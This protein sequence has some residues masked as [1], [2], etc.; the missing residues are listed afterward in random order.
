MYG[1][2]PNLLHPRS[3]EMFQ[4]ISSD[5]MSFKNESLPLIQP[6]DAIR[7]IAKQT[8]AFSQPLQETKLFNLTDVDLMIV[9]QANSILSGELD[10]T[11]NGLDS[12]FKVWLNMNEVVKSE[13]FVRF[14][15][16]AIIRKLSQQDLQILKQVIFNKQNLPEEAKNWYLSWLTVACMLTEE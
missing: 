2:F 6:V 14:G 7:K 5:S 11:E 12:H 10:L 8:S 15:E 13:K 9:R 3:F 1:N 4:D 16:S